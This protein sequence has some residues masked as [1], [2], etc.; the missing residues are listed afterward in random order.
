MGGGLQVASALNLQ[1]LRV[2]RKFD[3]ARGSG[4]SHSMGS[5]GVKGLGGL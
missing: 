2:L 4:R 3:R 1:V 5:V